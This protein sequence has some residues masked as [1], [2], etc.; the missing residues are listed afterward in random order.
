LKGYVAATLIILALC[1]AIGQP[2]VQFFTVG[3][4]AEIDYKQKFGDD[5]VMLYDSSSFEGQHDYLMIIWNRMNETFSEKPLSQYYSSGMWW[6]QTPSNTLDAQNKWFNG[7][8]MSINRYINQTQ[9][10]NQF[11]SY[12]TLLNQSRQ[13][14]KANGGVDWALKGAYMLEFHPNWAWAWLTTLYYWLAAVVMI[15]VAV[16]ILRI[17]S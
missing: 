7:A 10:P 9:Q 16:L 5:V 17:N 4:Q 6:D 2:I 15:I 13:E 12:Q 3:I 11:I 14:L 8:L 1:I